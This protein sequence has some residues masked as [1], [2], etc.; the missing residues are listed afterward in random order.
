MADRWF[1]RGTGALPLTFE[2]GPG[3]NELRDPQMG[4]R[5]ILPPA[6]GGTRKIADLPERCT[7]FDHDPPGNQVFPPGIYEHICSS[8]GKRQ[9]FRV[10]AVIC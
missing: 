6:R 3:M 4:T 7:A 2:P 8:C 5:P 10:D 9:V 1:R